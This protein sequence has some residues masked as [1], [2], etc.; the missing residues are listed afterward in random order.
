M[1]PTTSVFARDLSLHPK[2]A[3]LLSIEDR[4][5]SL[6]DV[7]RALN[8]ATNKNKNDSDVKEG[9][10]EFGNVGHLGNRIQVRRSYKDG[11]RIE[12]NTVVG[13]FEQKDIY[14]ENLDNTPVIFGNFKNDIRLVM[15]KDKEELLICYMNGDYVKEAIVVQD[16]RVRPEW[17]ISQ[18]G[19]TVFIFT[20]D[21]DGN[22]I[23]AEYF[24][25]TLLKLHRFCAPLFI[26]VAEPLA[27]KPNIR[28][29][30]IR[31]N[32]YSDTTAK[33]YRKGSLEGDLVL[34]Y[35]EVKNGKDLD[36]YIDYPISYSDIAA[37]QALQFFHFMDLVLVADPQQALIDARYELVEKL[38]GLYPD[39]INTVDEA[40]NPITI[41]DRVLD[42]K[43]RYEEFKKSPQ[44]AAVIT[45]FRRTPNKIIEQYYSFLRA[46]ASPDRLEVPRTGAMAK[47][48][49]NKLEEA[50]KVD[51]YKTFKEQLADDIKE[52]WEDDLRKEGIYIERLKRQTS[53]I[54]SFTEKFLTVQNMKRA[55]SIVAVLS[56]SDLFLGTEFIT[57]F[58]AGVVKVLSLT[59]NIPVLGSFIT[60]P[61]FSGIETLQYAQ[62]QKRFAF[63]FSLMMSAMPLAYYVAGA[64]EYGI[65]SFKTTFTQKATAFYNGGLQLYRL[66]S[67]PPQ[68]PVIKDVLRQKNAYDALDHGLS[69]SEKGFFNS[70]FASSEE[71][72][73]NRKKLSNSVHEKA[74]RSRQFEWLVTAVLVAEMHDIDVATLLM[75]SEGL[76][77]YRA[78]ALREPR[79]RERWAEL[80]VAV[81]QAT[82]ELGHALDSGEEIDFNSEEF[83]KKFK[84]LA[85]KATFIEQQREKSPEAARLLAFAKRASG[86]FLRN[87]VLP[88]LMG[89]PGREIQQQLAGAKMDPTS[90]HQAHVMGFGDSLASTALYGFT[91]IPAFSWPTQTRIAFVDTPSQVGIMGTQGAY[92]C[93]SG[94]FSS[95]FT[96]PAISMTHYLF[97]D[98]SAEKLPGDDNTRGVYR[99]QTLWEATKTITSAR[100]D[101]TK[102]S[103]LERHAQFIE[104][105]KNGVQARFTLFAVPLMVGYLFDGKFSDPFTLL[106]SSTFGTLFSMF[107][108]ISVFPT[109]GYATVWPGVATA[110][111]D[112]T[113]ATR[114]NLAKTRAVFAAIHRALNINSIDE[115]RD[116]VQRLQALYVEGNTPLPARLSIAAADYTPALAKEL[117]L[118]GLHM[119][120]PLPTVSNNTMNYLLNFGL[121][122][123]FSVVLYNIGVSQYLFAAGRSMGELALAAVA[124]AASMAGTWVTLKVASK[125]IVKPVLNSQIV[126]N[127][128]GTISNI[129][130]TCTSYLQS[131]V[132]DPSKEWEVVHA[133]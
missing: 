26:G 80:S 42:A 133:N 60:D 19:D 29:E 86:N 10:S 65:Y 120:L 109:L 64:I 103:V 104:N 96:D 110:M 114:A 21:K 3:P 97:Y 81:E 76:E 77:V 129:E 127:T 95:S 126:K 38:A 22:P 11:A 54:R 92:D 39:W 85:D 121:G 52:K 8:N 59:T 93:L 44:G 117:L 12:G 73:E 83:Q 79:I 113:D 18:D 74:E 53:L 46:K 13:E 2:I 56:G 125:S 91:A 90:A 102:R 111:G 107:S 4:D 124:G 41:G 130:R 112:L 100:F 55:A 24:S 123:I 72:S 28:L 57:P 75:Q 78:S 70:P 51:P 108:K 34:R 9:K 31:E 68:A 131:V 25:A 5:E 58:V 40:G 69:P 119:R 23:A 36:R 99:Q 66:I 27:N 32:L 128:V 1:L 118:Y 84:A 106:A 20:E 105:T 116:G 16:I 98:E 49:L 14:S 17:F 67:S 45:Y 101:P 87:D 82:L 33:R 88:F 7:V 43:R 35:R 132:S 71:I 50:R 94:N 62:L 122:T 47:T 37:K 30:S 115:I 89:Q 61:I 6:A 63:G 15:D 48:L